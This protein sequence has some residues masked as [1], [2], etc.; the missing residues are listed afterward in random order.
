MD[1]IIL[2]ELIKNESYCKQVI[3][4]LKSEYFFDFVDELIFK[5]IKNTVDSYSPEAISP[6][7]LLL[8]LDADN[9][10]NNTS[11]KGAVEALEDILLDTTSAEKN[12]LIDQTDTFIK[13]KATRLAVMKAIE[14][15]DDPNET[16]GHL[17]E[18]LSEALSQTLHND[19]G[20]NWLEDAKTR[21]EFYNN[22][23][24]KFSLGLN[25]LNDATTGGVTK[26]TLNIIAAAINSGKSLFLTSL[27]THFLHKY[28]VL[29][30]TLEMS[31]ERIAERIDANLMRIPL[32]NL[33]KLNEEQYMELLKKAATQIKGELIIKEY[34]TGCGSVNDFNALLEELRIKSDF[35]PDV[36]LVDYLGIMSSTRYKSGTENSYQYV[37]AISEELRGFAIRHNLPVFTATQ[38][39]RSA[40]QSDEQAKMTDVSESI[41]L[42]ATA[43]LMISLQS[44]DE[45]RENA[46]VK[47]G[48]IKNRFGPQKNPFLANINYAEMRISDID[49]IIDTIPKN[50][51]TKPKFRGRGG[52]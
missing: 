8:A 18:L 33:H 38:I 24:E 21:Y 13:D 1:K 19:V 44:S 27:A 3:P 35:V 14:I 17:P 22:P 4:Y 30:I 50:I 49:D 23:E 29:Y 28:K 47:L 26:K 36:V 10:V 9:S 48:I 5:H 12:W 37:K 31:Q 41:G 46:Q 16:G 25:S 15:I 43:D 52:S 32:N 7:T 42:A 45:L 11:Y 51:K 2:R 20:H 39:N 6:E 40:M 34:P